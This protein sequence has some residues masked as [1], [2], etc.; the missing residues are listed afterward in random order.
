[1]SWLM[2]LLFI[3]TLVII[4]YIALGAKKHMNKESSITLH[5]TQLN[6]KYSWLRDPAWPKVTN[7]EIL[8]YLKEQNIKTDEFFLINST[9]KEQ[10]FKEFQSRIELE[11]VSPY[12]KKDNF[13]YY[14]RISVD[15]NYRVYCRKQA[16]NA[17]ATEEILLDHN[18][19][20]KGHEFSALGAMA[21]SP[22]QKLLAY[23]VDFKGDEHY[24]I[25]ILNLDTKTHLDDEIPNAIGQI[26][27]HETIPGFFYSQLDDKW[28]HNKIF[29]HKLG[30]AP[31]EDILIYHEK[32]ELFNVSVNKSGS[33]SYIFIMVSGH[34]SSE[35]HYINMED[36]QF[37]VHLLAPRKDEI[38]YQIDHNGDYFYILTN[39]VG[40]NYRVARTLTTKAAGEFWQDYIALDDKKFIDSFNLTQNYFIINYK[41]EG[42]VISDIIEISSN[43]VKSLNYKDD[44]YE[45]YCYSTNFKEDDIRYDYSSLAQ[46]LTIYQFNFDTENSITLKK[47]FMPKEFDETQ[48]KVER[49]WVES[50]NVKV[51]VSILYKEKLFKNDGSNPLFLY[52]YGSYGISIPMGFNKFII[53]LLDRG[54]VYAI[55]HIRGGGEMGHSWHKQAKFLNKKRTFD[56]FIAVS[57]DLILN[58]YSS[59]GNIVIAG[60]SAGG[61]L[62][63]NVINQKP[64]LYKAAILQV[65]FVDVLNTML[66]ETLPLTP[67]EFKEWGN[68]KEKEYFEYMLSYSPYENIK[69]QNYPNIFITTGLSDPRV[70][71]WEGAKFYAKLQEL[72]L[73]RNVLLLQTNMGAG[74]GGASGRYDYLKEKADSYVFAIKSFD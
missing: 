54:F 4:L 3:C 61:M 48:Y 44:V 56:D 69:A 7:E 59:Q 53:S 64:E 15:Q 38:F 13:L 5:N 16:N 9:L 73:D 25:K 41:N 63:G 65:P 49:I 8:Q 62:I 12:I 45:S 32:D 55:A 1:M 34:N 6:D 37:K 27:W 21:V 14:N 24:T 26:V 31:S 43:K 42:L 66:D 19:L 30:T 46:P 68:P 50:E 39:D 22:S 71:Y 67:G 74:H 2:A 36:T 60:G 72:R 52:G 11:D 58:N 20:A 23:S 35:C 10:I 29:F 17:S 70:G 40:D 33:K 28:R 57:E 51:P 18:D 47:Q